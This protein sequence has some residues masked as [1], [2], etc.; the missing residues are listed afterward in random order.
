M[1]Q[2]ERA[3]VRLAIMERILGLLDRCH[4][5]PAPICRSAL[6]PCTS[7][8]DMHWHSSSHNCPLWSPRIVPPVAFAASTL[9]SCV[10]SVVL[11]KGAILLHF[12]FASRTPVNNRV[13]SARLV[14]V[15][16]TP[17]SSHSYSLLGCCSARAGGGGSS[18]HGSADRPAATLHYPRARH[19]GEEG[20]LAAGA[21]ARAS[22]NGVIERKVLRELDFRENKSLQTSE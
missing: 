22:C 21:G 19:H 7:A 4:P 13:T 16:M 5:T 15:W 8:P 10:M 9:R 3:V 14:H 2:L 17:C 20:C 6:E 18:V 11:D 12:F 1:H